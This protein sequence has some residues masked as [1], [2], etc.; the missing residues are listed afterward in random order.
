MGIQKNSIELFNSVRDRLKYCK[1]EYIK[2]YENLVKYIWKS[3][4]S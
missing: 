4:L 2:D 3:H 1:Y